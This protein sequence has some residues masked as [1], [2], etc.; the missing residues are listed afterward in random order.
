[1]ARTLWLLL[2]ALGGAACGAESDDD[3]GSGGAGGSASTGGSAG[4]SCTL[5][6]PEPGNHVY[7]LEHDGLTRS[8]TLHV[9]TTPPTEPTPLILNF[10]GFTSSMSGQEAFSLMSP[11]SDAHGYVVA[12][13]NGV[14]NSWNAGTCCATDKTRDDVGFVRKVV[15]DIGTRLCVDPRR[16]YATGMS[17]GGYLSYRLACEAS[18][19]FAAIAPVA[20]VLGIP[21]SECAPTHPMP[22]LHFHGTADGLVA[23]D[24]AGGR[25]VPDLVAWW[26]ER[27][28]CAPTASTTLQHGT[29]TCVTYSACTAGA[30]AT[31]CTLEGEGHCWPGQPSCP[32]GAATTD[33][34][35]ND[36]MWTF[37][38]RFELQ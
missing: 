18:D 7:E 31:L 10:H 9:P 8:Y 25:S 16:V 27:N 21:D 3:A 35:A 30:D 38:Q 17:N 15:A 24:G 4:S 32:F 5:T 29:G 6:S 22:L 2:A 20:G 19:L 12:Y 37:F 13:P 33:V 11:H 36:E 28:G 23:Y 26:A 34:V 14:S 1:M